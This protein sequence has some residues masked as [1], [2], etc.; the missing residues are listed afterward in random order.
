VSSP[1]FGKRGAIHARSLKLRADRLTLI[2]QWPC[3]A[4]WENDAPMIGQG[5]S[6]RDSTPGFQ[7]RAFRRLARRR[8]EC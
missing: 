6:A 4:A 1:D 7:G 3:S 5:A 2:W 8:I